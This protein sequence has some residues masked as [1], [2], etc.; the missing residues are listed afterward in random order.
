MIFVL[1]FSKIFLR[2]YIFVHVD[3][4]RLRNNLMVWEWSKRKCFILTIQKSNVAT[5]TSYFVIENDHHNFIVK[6]YFI[7]LIRLFRII[8]YSN[9]TEIKYYEQKKQ[10]LNLSDFRLFNEFI[11]EHFPNNFHLKHSRTAHTHTHTSDSYKTN[12]WRFENEWLW[13][14]KVYYGP[15]AALNLVDCTTGIWQILKKKKR[16]N[17]KYVWI[18]YISFHSS[19]FNF[20]HQFCNYP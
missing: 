19:I 12:V 8:Y 2:F 9:Y 4:Y 6:N 15:V 10:R 7:R 3:L 1:F 5:S 13:F 20:M 18:E 17:G 11:I 14:G 16:N